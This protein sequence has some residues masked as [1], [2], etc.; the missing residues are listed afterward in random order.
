M[1]LKVPALLALVAF[2]ITLWF[3]IS[4]SP[5][6]MVLFTF[7]AQPLFLIVAVLYVRQVFKELREKEV[8]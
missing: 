5:Y 6:P 2:A 7:I 1:R 4:P 3:V 8:L